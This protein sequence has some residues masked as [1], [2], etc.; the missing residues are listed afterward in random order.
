MENLINQIRSCKRYLDWKKRVLE[1][2]DYKC[3]NCG[4]SLIGCRSSLQIHHRKTFI[5]ILKDNNITTFEQAI[6]CKELWDENNG[7]IL[8]SCCHI[9][10]HISEKIR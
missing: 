6:E 1:N 9:D 2:N 10:Y 3:N 5:D 4:A 8:C 7:I